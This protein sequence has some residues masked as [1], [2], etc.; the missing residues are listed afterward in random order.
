M[1]SLA[2]AFGA[3]LILGW[4]SGFLLGMREPQETDEERT[5]RLF[6]EGL[7]EVDYDS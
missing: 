1:G 7:E 6:R 5:A 4:V 3:G 2:L